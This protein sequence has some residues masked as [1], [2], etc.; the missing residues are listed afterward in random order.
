MSRSRITAWF[1]AA[2]LIL[3]APLVTS[4]SSEGATDE[5]THGEVLV[6]TNG[7]AKAAQADGMT[8][9]FGTLENTGD[10]DIELLGVESESAGLIEFH[11]VTEDSVMQ[12]IAGPV[13]VPAHG[14]FELAPGA[15]H[16]MLMELR[17]DLLA[18]DEVTF[19]LTMDADGQTHAQTFT[20]L[21]KDFSG[22]NEDYADLQHDH[23]SHGGGD[24]H[25]GDHGVSDHATDDHEARD[26]SGETDDHGSH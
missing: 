26:H 2:L 24:D 12:E 3:A 14:A 15:N 6:L 7:W 11:E 17:Q 8:G 20:V 5:T 16:I 13:I 21:V 9:V 10:V 19:T 22:A 1:T 4:C 23:G 18:G 25:E